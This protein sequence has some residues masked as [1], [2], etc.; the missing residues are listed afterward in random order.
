MECVSCR[1]H[2][3]K[4]V[5]KGVEFNGVAFMPVLEVLESNLSSL[6]CSADRTKRQ[7]WQF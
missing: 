5:R 3:I 2:K 6:A 7:P 4:N 1:V